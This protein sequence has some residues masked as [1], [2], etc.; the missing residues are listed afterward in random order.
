[1]NTR[2]APK[3]HIN[4]KIAPHFTKSIFIF[5]HNPY[6]RFWY[7]NPRT[8]NPVKGQ[9]LFFPLIAEARQTIGK[10]KYSNERNL[11]SAL[12]HVRT[13]SCI[14]SNPSH[15]RNKQ[16]FQQGR[17]FAVSPVPCGR[18]L[19]TSNPSHQRNKQGFQQGQR[20]AVSSVP[21]GRIP[22]TSN[23]SHQRNKQGFQQVQ[24]FAVSPV[25][26]G[27]IPVTPNPSH[28]RNKQ[29]FQQGRQSAVSSVACG[30]ILASVCSPTPKTIPTPSTAQNACKGK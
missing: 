5:N 3:A 4:F 11:F 6:L 24:R 16:G 27:R 23:P 7:K 19:V 15:Q 17:W 25:P 22:V 20:F 10:T 26:C 2:L 21:C 29:G 30:R 1:M 28:Q 8:F 12:G 14:H 18:I 9:A 13:H